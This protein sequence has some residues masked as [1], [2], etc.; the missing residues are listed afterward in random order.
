VLFAWNLS[1]SAVSKQCR[2]HIGG[3]PPCV[4]GD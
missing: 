3:I 1:K 2:T 4:K